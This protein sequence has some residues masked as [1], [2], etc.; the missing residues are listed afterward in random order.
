MGCLK[1]NKLRDNTY[2]MQ[3]VTKYELSKYGFKPKLPDD[4]NEY[5][6]LKFPVCKYKNKPTLFGEFILDIKT[7]TV[8]INLYHMNG[9]VYAPFYH[10]S[11]GNYEVII[12]KINKNI[13][14][15]MKD[16]KITQVEVK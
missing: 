16:L 6:S 9:D 3:E 11:H 5:F 14:N 8:D 13:I 7:W 1:N 12:N 15:K 4:N 10:N 2:K